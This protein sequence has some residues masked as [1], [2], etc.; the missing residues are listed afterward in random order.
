MLLALRLR[1]YMDRKKLSRCFQLASIVQCHTLL[2][3]FKSC[4]CCSTQKK[5]DQNGSSTCTVCPTKWA[6]GLEISTVYC[7]S[8][9]A[10]FGVRLHFSMPDFSWAG[11]VVRAYVPLRTSYSLE[12][13]TWVSPATPCPRGTINE[14]IE[15]CSNNARAC[16][17]SDYFDPYTYI[18]VH[19]GH[20]H[21]NCELTASN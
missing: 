7:A 15:F 16:P 12:N 17:V 4:T 13:T 11:C 3:W 18:S 21:N 19:Y 10:C 6:Y 8:S 9:N 14:T 20:E 5:C 2:G 1:D